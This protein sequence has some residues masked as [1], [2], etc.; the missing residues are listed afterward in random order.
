MKLKF[1]RLSTVGERIGSFII[2]HF[3]FLFLFIAVIAA[4]LSIFDVGDN[5]YFI[6]VFIMMVP[7]AYALKD[8][9][10][11]RSLG[12]RVFGIAVRCIENV[13]AI[14]S[15]WRLFLRNITLVILPI[16]FLIMIFN[17]DGTRLGDLLAKTIVVKLEK[18]ESENVEAAEIYRAKN[19]V[20][21][22]VN[23]KKVLKISLISFLILGISIVSFI[24]GISSLMKN[25][26]AYKV[27][28]SQIENSSE[29]TTQIG[30]IK[31]YGFM[32]TGSI[33][34]N[35]GSGEAQFVIKVKGER[36][37]TKVFSKLYK[38]NNEGWRIVEFRILE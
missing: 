10:N 33:S 5:Y 14:P 11:G 12:K 9:I 16:E 23:R 3:V 4:T 29:I 26:G 13:S 30:K 31:G 17:P 6:I 37:N 24:G 28:I 19:Y 36:G 34:T 21:N 22:Q 25:N 1:K 27:T 2:D 18:S 15:K 20:R 32:P 38:E 7:L 35:N 8:E